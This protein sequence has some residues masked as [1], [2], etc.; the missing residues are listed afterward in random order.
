MEAFYV[1]VG[2]QDTDTDYYYYWLS[3]VI[4]HSSFIS[5]EVS[6]CLFLLNY[7]VYCF[8]AVGSSFVADSL[9]LYQ[10]VILNILW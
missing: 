10:M 8:M 9:R 6:C 1:T 5:L 2:F 3:G 7:A 4:K